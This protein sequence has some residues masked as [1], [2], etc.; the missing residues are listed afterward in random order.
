MEPRQ[1]L[2]W[3]LLP[4]IPPSSGPW[5]AEW[6][7][8]GVCVCVCNVETL[9]GASKCCTSLFKKLLSKLWKLKRVSDW[10][11]VL[12]D[13]GAPALSRFQQ[14]RDSGVSLVQRRL[15]I[16]GWHQRS[17]ARQGQ[18]QG[19]IIVSQL[20]KGS[21]ITQIRPK[22][23]N[24]PWTN[25]P[26]GHQAALTKSSKAEDLQSELKQSEQSDCRLMNNYWYLYSSLVPPVGPL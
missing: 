7:S 2:T 8:E 13:R 1:L 9:Q 18:W 14:N 10:C 23:N 12:P 4:R 3:R 15:L 24:H 26:P 25:N 17:W 19:Y 20:V 22:P 11:W 6:G 16:I 5:T 21:L